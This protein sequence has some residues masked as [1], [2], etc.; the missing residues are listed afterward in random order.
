[1]WTFI[2]VHILYNIYIPSLKYMSSSISSRFESLKG[3]KHLYSLNSFSL[4][5]CVDL[6]F[7]KCSFLLLMLSFKS[8]L[9][10]F[11]SL[12]KS[13]NV[14]KK[15]KLFSFL[16]FVNNFRALFTKQWFKV[17]YRILLVIWLLTFRNWSV[18]Q[19]EPVNH[20]KHTKLN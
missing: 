13:R 1:M 19:N 7:N 3:P 20:F 9:N 16:L 2:R 8:I 12:T 17:Y 18:I 14:K 4:G 11:I 5:M 10:Q 15:M 6:R